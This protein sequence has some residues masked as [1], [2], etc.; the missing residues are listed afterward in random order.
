M[1][2]QVNGTDDHSKE[3]EKTISTLREDCLRMQEE[4]QKALKIHKANK[5][6]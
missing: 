5:V 4:V 1:K 6:L 3:Q 2:N